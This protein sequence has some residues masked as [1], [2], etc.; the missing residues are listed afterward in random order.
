MSKSKIIQR[1]LSRLDDSTVAVPYLLQLFL[2]HDTLSV[3]FFSSKPCSKVH[4]EGHPA[5]TIPLPAF[6]PPNHFTAISTELLMSLAT[7][8]CRGSANAPKW[9]S[10][11]LKNKGT[12]WFPLSSCRILILSCK[13][14]SVIFTF[15]GFLHY[16]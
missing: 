4:A 10:F 12:S 16:S 6:T 2:H 1:T 14:R 3:A 5:Q 9:H 7:L 15:S 11:V 13:D 8:H